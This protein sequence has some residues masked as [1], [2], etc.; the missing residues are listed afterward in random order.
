MS[1]VFVKRFN[2]DTRKR[3]Y[4]PYRWSLKGNKRK[5]LKHE[6]YS[7][8]PEN[9][10]LFINPCTLSVWWK[11]QDDS[12]KACVAYCPVLMVFSTETY[13]IIVQYFLPE[14]PLSTRYKYD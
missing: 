12:K 7:I 8:L 2:L 5:H 10:Q 14:R 11:Q 9:V 4:F 6:F 1:I 13:Y 3:I